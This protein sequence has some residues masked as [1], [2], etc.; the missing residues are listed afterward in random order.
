MASVFKNALKAGVGTTP[1][2]CYTAPVGGSAT[3]IGLTIANVADTAV[4]VDIKVVDVSEVVTAHLAKQIMIPVR[5]SLIVVGGEQKVVLEAGDYFS[6]SSSV[7]A[8]A[9]VVGSLLEVV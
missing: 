1:V 8:G 5:G 2:T 4:Y 7:S 6:V 3:I 9:D